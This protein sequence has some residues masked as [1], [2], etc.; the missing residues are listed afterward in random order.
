MSANVGN[1]QPK[2]HTIDGHG[3]ASHT[4]LLEG[5]L[6]NIRATIFNADLRVRSKRRLLLA[7]VLLAVHRGLAL[8][9]VLK[10]QATKEARS[11]RDKDADGDRELRRNTG[12]CCQELTVDP[13]DVSCER[14]EQA[15]KLQHLTTYPRRGSTR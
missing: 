11:T 9:A 1:E 10:R 7:S 5:E 15:R 2:K 4:G 3:P 13:C 8:H 12:Q 6:L 14:C